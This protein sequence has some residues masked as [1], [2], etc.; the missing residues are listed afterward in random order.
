MG[1]FG[2]VDPPGMP[3]TDGELL[4]TYSGDTVLH[5]P[6]APTPEEDVELLRRTA[7]ELA[8]SYMKAPRGSRGSG[9]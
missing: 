3:A 7:R 5:I 4:P 9:A 8:E 6:R 2:D 1:F